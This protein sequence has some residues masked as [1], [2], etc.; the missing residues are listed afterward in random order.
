M[1]AMLLR[2]HPLAWL[3]ALAGPA[4]AENQALDPA[5]LAATVMA[6]DRLPSLSIVVG[7]QGKVLYSAAF[8]LADVENAVPASPKTVYRIG[9]IAKTVTATAIMQLVERGSLDLDVPIQTYCQ[10]FPH[11]EAE[12]TARLLLAHLGGIRDYNYQRFGEEF[13]SSKRYGSVTEALAVFKDD[14][15]AAEPGEKYLYSSFGYVLLGCAIEQA[16]G[17]RFGEYL[18][19]NVFQPAR[20]Q[21]SGLDVPEQIV[22]HRARLY[23]RDASGAWA[24]SPFVDLSDRFPAGGLLSTPTDMAFFGMALLEGRLLTSDTWA[25]MIKPQRNQSGERVDYGL[26][27]R[28]SDRPGEAFHGGTSVGGSAYL[29]LTVDTATVVALA[30]NVDRWT[31]GRHELALALAEWAEAQ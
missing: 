19:R 14:P 4:F 26:G 30:T 27:W 2:F 6:K 13:L 28:L 17:L 23:S 16:S 11:K 1:I 29:Y 3:L 15:L 12:V 24:N 22:P 8:G 18:G 10:S 25:A 7:R 31:E 5:A 20:M 21:Q 9:S